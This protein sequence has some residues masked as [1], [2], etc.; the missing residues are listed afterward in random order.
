[1]QPVEVWRG[2][3]GD[4]VPL[5]GPLPGRRDGAALAYEFELP[6]AYQP[7]PD[8][9]RLER[10]FVLLDVGVGMSLPSWRTRA[11]PDGTMTPG[12]DAE[13]SGR[14]TWYVDLV[15]ITDEGDTVYVRDLWIDVMVPT[16]GR[17]PRMLDLEEFAD[18]IE[19]GSLPVPIAMDGL[20]RWQAFLDRCL[21]L[22][23]DPRHGYTDFPPR[24]LDG[25]RAAPRPFGP[26][27]PAPG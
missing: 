14:V 2:K 7:W 21:H 22:G 23:R 24:A 13:A 17:H 25:L 12:V 16:D 18:A 19:T 4:P 6:P 10:S 5:F 3:Y 8:R 11:E 9:D 1:M 26:V 20:R 27:V 15:E